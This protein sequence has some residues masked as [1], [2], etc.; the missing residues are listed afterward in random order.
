V[1]VCVFC[2][3]CKQTLAV[4]NFL[5]DENL[6][7][8]PAKFYQCLAIF[9]FYSSGHAEVLTPLSLLPVLPMGVA[10][11][12][13]TV[14]CACLQAER[15]VPCVRQA[16]FLSGQ[17]GGLQHMRFSLGCFFLVVLIGNGRCFNAI[18]TL[19]QRA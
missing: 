3:A 14:L 15:G 2:I 12:H 13:C 1:R 7:D 4:S 8:D 19:S 5:K 6:S 11:A 17:S 18:L 10:S 16:H 9:L